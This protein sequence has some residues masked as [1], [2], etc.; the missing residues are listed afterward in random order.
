MSSVPCRERTFELWLAHDFEYH[1]RYYLHWLKH[2]LERLGREHALTLWQDAF[3][4]YDEQLLLQILATGWQEV[5]ESEAQDVEKQVADLLAELFPSPVEGISS[6]QAQEILE[7]TPP[8]RQIRQHLPSPNVKRASTTYEA[9][10]LFRDA[11]AQLAEALIDRYGKQG[12]LL[13]YDTILEEWPR[14]PE[15]KVSVEDFMSRRKIRFS[16]EPD[17]PDMFSA[18][19]QVEFVHASETEVVTRVTE[20][21][22]ARYFR[23]RHPR[24]GYMLACSLDNPAYRSFNDRIR[25][26]RTTTLMEGGTECDFRVYAVAEIPNPD[27]IDGGI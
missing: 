15:P 12:E 27:D 10:H 9:L 2:L 8:F 24:V 11:V 3:R 20:C 25:L 5:E 23:E 17:E 1:Y 14:D 6:E 26:Q 21:E 4:E 19:L 22:W 18:G 16:T 7:T 13:A